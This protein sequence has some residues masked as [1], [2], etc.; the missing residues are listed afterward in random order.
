MQQEY[1][2]DVIVDLLKSVAWVRSYQECCAN[3]VEVVVGIYLAQ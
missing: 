2:D 1:D 3:H